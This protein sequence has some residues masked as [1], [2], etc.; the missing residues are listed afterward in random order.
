M[1]LAVDMDMVS[2]GHNARIIGSAMARVSIAGAPKLPDAPERRT[3]R[4][5]ALPAPEIPV[6]R[7]AYA[8]SLSARRACFL[9]S[10][11]SR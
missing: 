9:R 4:T 10:C 7:E 8:A 2:G 6:L 3:G 11:G 1:F 5:F